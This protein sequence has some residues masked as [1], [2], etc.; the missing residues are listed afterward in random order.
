M[1]AERRSVLLFAPA[2]LLLFA[3]GGSFGF[4]IAIP[5]AVKFLVGFGGGL[6]E[7]ML[8][9]GEYVSFVGS[10]LLV[11]GAAFEI[12]VVILFLV[13][14]KVVTPR[15]L[16]AYRRHAILALVIA[17]AVLTPTPDAFTQ[18]LLAVPLIGLYEISIWL[19]KWSYK[20]NL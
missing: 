11:F 9:I 13:R 15:A 5:L 8:S 12:P 14:I 6:A 19:A 4:F 7:P 3:L 18:L 10:L 1:P 2:S 16:A 17:A 20:P